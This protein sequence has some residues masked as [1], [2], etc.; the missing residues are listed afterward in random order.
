MEEKVHE[1]WVGG[2]LGRVTRTKEMKRKGNERVGGQKIRKKEK[3]RKRANGFRKRKAV[4]E[5]GNG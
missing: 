5:Q 4:Q 3:D 2:A 1:I